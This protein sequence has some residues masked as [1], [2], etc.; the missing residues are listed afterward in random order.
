MSYKESPYKPVNCDFV[1][2]I[3]HLAALRKPVTIVY[4]DNLKVRF[5]K[6]VRIKTWENRGESGE[7]LILADNKGEIR[8]DYIGSINGKGP[9]DVCRVG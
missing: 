7:F 8:L 4:I 3:E 2:W 1:D 9:G 6:D 5:D